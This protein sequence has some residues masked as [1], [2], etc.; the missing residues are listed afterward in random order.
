MKA[1]SSFELVG[2]LIGVDA[3]IIS[4][5][6]SAEVK[7]ILD[8]AAVMTTVVPSVAESIGYTHA[9]RVGLSV[10]RTAA[11]DEHGYIV[12]AEVEALGFAMREHPVVVAELGY[13]IDGVLGIDF[14][15]EFNIE[16]RFAERRILVESIAPTSHT[17][18]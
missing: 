1:E 7:L 9:N 17:A 4:P 2:D 13:G 5:T 11:A 15:R 8:T 3:V 14:L 16:I 10:T 6:G 12:R 18:D